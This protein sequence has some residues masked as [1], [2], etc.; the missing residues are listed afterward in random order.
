MADARAEKLVNIVEDLLRS[1]DLESAIENMEARRDEYHP[2]P[3][4]LTLRVMDNKYLKVVAAPRCLLAVVVD[5]TGMRLPLIQIDQ[6]L[7]ETS[8]VDIASDV[9]AM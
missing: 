1:G 3:S 7:L 6:G 9:L 8:L 5:G 4:K 2:V